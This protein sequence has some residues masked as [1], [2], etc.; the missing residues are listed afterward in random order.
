LGNI[1]FNNYSVFN[2]TESYLRGSGIP[3]I[4]RNQY[5]HFIALFHG[6]VNNALTDLGYN[7]SNQSYK[8]EMFDHH[9]IALL[10]D[11]HMKQDL[12]YSNGLEKPLVHY[13]GSLIQQNHGETLEHHGISLWDLSQ[14]KY[15][16]IDIPNDYGYYTI[17]ID[18][19]VL[20]TDISDIPKK[21]RLRIQCFE[22][23][24]TEVKAVLTKI[25]ALVNVI[26]VSYVRLDSPNTQQQSNI[27]SNISLSNL[28][29]VDYQ[30]NLI[31]DYLKKKLDVKL[32]SDIDDVLKIN[33]ETNQHLKK[34]D[35]VKNIRWKP[36]RFE[37]DNMF[38]Y[39]EGNVIDFSK[40]HDVVGLFAPNTSGK[41]SILS[42]LSFCIFDKCDRDFKASNVINVQKMGF[43]CK[44]NFEVSGVD[45]FIERWG[46]LDKK[47]NVA[48]KV[49]F[50][51]EENGVA[52]DLHAESRRETNDV[53]REYL[54]T[55][56][57]FV[58]TSL[59]IQNV[60]NVSSFIDM[61][62]TE[63]KDLLA[64]FM[65]L[66]IFD[67]LYNTAQDKLK[68]L[69]VLL[70]QYKR[71]DFTKKLV[72]IVGALTQS[73]S[74]FNSTT[75]DITRMETI[76]SELQKT[77]LEEAKNIIK[78]DGSIPDKEDS[79]LIEKKSRAA[80]DKY[81]SELS[82]MKLANIGCQD[83]LSKLELGIQ[84]LE[85][86]NIG[87][88]FKSHQSLLSR[89]SDIQNQIDSLKVQVQ[90]KL[91][92]IERAREF[93]YDPEC[94]Y[95]VEN[96]NDL[97]KEAAFAHTSLG[98][99]T[100]RARQLVAEIGEV[101][102]QIEDTRWS[103]E[104]YQSYTQMIGKRNDTKDKMVRLTN[105]LNSLQSSI[106]VESKRLQQAIIDIDLYDKNSKSLENNRHIEKTLKE[107]G[108]RVINVDVELKKKNKTILDLNGKISI[109][110]NQIA[111]FEEK[112][113]KAKGIETDFQAYTSY[114][115]CVCRD[116]IPY[117]VIS[118]MVPQIE[119]EVNNILSQIVEFHVHFDVDGK[120]VT[121]Y[122]VYDDRKWIMSLSSGFE[123]FVLSLA[124]R[125]ALI[126]VSN[127]PRPNFLV[128]DEGFGVLD[129]DN[130]ASMHTLFSFLKSNFDF[131]M[132]VS[133]LD[134]LRD[135]VDKLVEIKKDVGFSKVNFE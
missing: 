3:S 91:E 63:R 75:E 101:K 135:M 62:N 13:C 90:H 94:E 58:L 76:R 43:K 19:G 78:L 9:D 47:G 119:K 134:S 114:V 37:F 21:V 109:Y 11:I 30:N 71:D 38:S 16:H 29:D 24:Q 117:E 86:Q 105:K 116:G 107:I 17:K 54:G 56:D 132:I 65:G 53:I 4:Y 130:I 88:V 25:R 82:E 67:K 27:C 6:P 31:I 85:E 77:L 20:V 70:R 15:E 46:Y 121:P 42:A 41:S 57:D 103:V 12:Q 96:A 99:D 73:E 133:H 32:Q 89:Q 68:E 102:K 8:L 18:R 112:I 108:Q 113:Q 61:G 69:T 100:E 23:V 80:L 106:D 81:K 49:K 123:K 60:K 5:D 110:K 10:G 33:R 111:T 44:F 115:Q 95:C 125:S 50:W 72:E 74:V 51:K 39:G 131:I 93:K 14:T 128:I 26:E 34:D 59:S 118:S 122:I 126:A 48:V 28:S 127:L 40:L 87:D 7:I 79:L 66:T 92:K 98:T 1:C 36:K 84:K 129:A 120:N 55:Y 104:L 22:S 35:L 64:Q 2:P 52:T 97:V 83:E 45:Y 124:I